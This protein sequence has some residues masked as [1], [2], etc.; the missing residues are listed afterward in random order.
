MLSVMPTWPSDISLS[1]L[2]K[3]C[4]GVQAGFA[5]HYLSLLIRAKQRVQARIACKWCD[6]G[7]VDGIRH[8]PAFATSMVLWC[9]STAS[10]VQPGQA[11]LPAAPPPMRLTLSRHSCS[12]CCLHTT[13]ALMH[14][15]N[16]CRCQELCHHKLATTCCQSI[17]DIL[18]VKVAV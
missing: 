16:L 14:D 18:A 1:T 13:A 10:A 2:R 4:S 11:C 7:K 15:Y 12:C 5:C 9:S 17:D 3:S 8:R 6:P